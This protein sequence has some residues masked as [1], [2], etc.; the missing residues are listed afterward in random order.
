MRI[1]RSASQAL[2]RTKGEI[3]ESKALDAEALVKTRSILLRRKGFKKVPDR[4]LQIVIGRQKSARRSR[5][6]LVALRAANIPFHYE[7]AVDAVDFDVYVRSED[8]LRANKIIRALFQS[9]PI[10]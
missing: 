6:V 3:D 1:R 10:E 5:R 8:A 7:V 2:A 9:D 4:P